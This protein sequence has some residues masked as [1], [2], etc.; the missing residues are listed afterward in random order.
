MWYERGAIEDLGDRIR[1]EGGEWGCTL[2]AA[3]Y[4]VGHDGTFS[5]GDRTSQASDALASGAKQNQ[6]EAFYS[7]ILK[8]KMSDL[9]AFAVAVCP[10]PY[11]G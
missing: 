5:V 11:F 3:S 2:V 7:D 10:Y 4:R 1:R 9:R 8:L 6:V